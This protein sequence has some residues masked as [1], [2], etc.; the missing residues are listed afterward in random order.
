L[1]KWQFAGFLAAQDT[2]DVTSGLTINVH[3]I[4]SIGD[5]SSGCRKYSAWVD[6]RHPVACHEEQD[7]CAVQVNRQIRRE[8]YASIRLLCHACNGVFHVGKIMDG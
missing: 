6:R 1:L 5:Q 4:R 7:L 3:C 2:I 8:K